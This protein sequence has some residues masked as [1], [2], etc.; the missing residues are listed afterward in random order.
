MSLRAVL[1]LT[2][3]IF[4]GYST[5][6]AQDT[7]F[8]IK[9][10]DELSE[11]RFSRMS[12]SWLRMQRHQWLHAESRH[13]IYHARTM[14]RLETIAREAEWAGSMLQSWIPSREPDDKS[15]IFIIEDENVWALILEKAG[16]REN[17]IALHV[18][19]E[20][21]ILRVESRP[22]SFV[23]LTHELVHVHL[24]QT[25]PD[26]LPL[27]LEEGLA[28]HLG[29][30]L[31]SAYHASRGIQLYRQQGEADLDAWIDW[32]TLFALRR[33]PDDP[34]R[35]RMFYRQSGALVRAWLEKH[36]MENLPAWLDRVARVA[37]KNQTDLLRESEDWIRMLDHVKQKL[38]Q[39]DQ[40]L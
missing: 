17:S 15:H 39:S 23:D 37:S 34:A 40:S 20:V 16:P 22:V 3:F 11:Q 31:A 27:W 30:K 33:Y 7:L 9:P 10:W 21:F 25:Y 2:C 32:D 35:N 1:L 5:V 28:E 8:E 14:R 18:D 4:P 36:G 26:A 29:W 19:R 12:K 38:H 24:A 6:Q 13:F